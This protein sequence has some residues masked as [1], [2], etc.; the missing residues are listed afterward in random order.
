MTFSVIFFFSSHWPLRT[1]LQIFYALRQLL[2]EASLSTAV[3]DEGGFAPALNSTDEA[4]G[5]IVKAIERAGYKPGD[6][7]M[8][9]LDAA[10]SGFYVDGKYDLVGEKCLLTTEQMNAMWQGVECSVSHCLNRG[11]V[12]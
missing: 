12:A 1:C 9:A 2:S 7:V 10:A 8:I 3:G 5:Y 11:S 6:D 4:I